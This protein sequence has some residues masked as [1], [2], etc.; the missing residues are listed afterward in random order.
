[1]L[2]IITMVA[3]GLF[4]MMLGNEYSVARGAE[5]GLAIGCFL[6]AAIWAAFAILRRWAE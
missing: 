1:M 5:I 3:G 4:A 2:P 6:V